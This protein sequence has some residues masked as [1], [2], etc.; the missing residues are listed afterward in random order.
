MEERELY[1]PEQVAQIAISYSKFCE[2]HSRRLYEQIAPK[3][4]IAFMD[5]LK[6][7]EEMIKELGLGLEIRGLD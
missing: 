7:L 2:G 6:N 5:K 1:S 3:N 4:V